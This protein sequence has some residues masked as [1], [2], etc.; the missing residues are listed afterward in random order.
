MEDQHLVIQPINPRTQNFSCFAIN[1][2]WMKE[3]KR[4][5]KKKREKIT[6]TVWQAFH[7]TVGEQ[8]YQ[9]VICI[10]IQNNTVKDWVIDGSESQNVNWNE[11][12][13]KPR[14]PQNWK[15]YLESKE[16]WQKNLDHFSI[17]ACHPCAGAMLIFSV[18]FQFYRMS[19]KRQPCRQ[20]CGIRRRESIASLS[21]WD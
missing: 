19:P 3:L 10:L 12:K 15:H 9:F 4:K 14:K 18:S 8:Q 20:L 7:H 21:I 16:D 1:K 2:Q 13:Q 6:K 11:E 5:R 17:Y